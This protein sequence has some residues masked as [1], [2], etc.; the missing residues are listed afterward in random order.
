MVH[1]LPVLAAHGGG[2]PFGSPNSPG[3]S[4]AAFF[5]IPFILL[6]LA[7]MGGFLYYLRWR[8]RNP[9]PTPGSLE[10]LASL[11]EAEPK[12]PPAASDPLEPW[13]RP[14]DWWKE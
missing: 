12:V 4:A 13:E 11:P 6:M 5:M 14:A 9:L 8:A 7:A 1:L 2:N 10:E 3:A